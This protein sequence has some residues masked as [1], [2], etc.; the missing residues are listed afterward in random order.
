MF[1]KFLLIVVLSFSISCFANTAENSSN[2][3]NTP[4]DSNKLVLPIQSDSS[5][6]TQASESSNDNN[7][8]PEQDASGSPNPK[9]QSPMIEY[10]R[11]HT[12]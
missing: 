11:K 5:N 1:N 10:C 6:K 12:C 7:S 8:A 9:K 3:S 2:T 4:V